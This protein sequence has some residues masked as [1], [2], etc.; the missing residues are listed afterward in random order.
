VG[1]SRLCC[2][3][4]SSG[5][6]ERRREYIIEWA[7]ANGW[8]IEKD[9]DGTVAVAV[10][11]GERVVSASFFDEDRIAMVQCLHSYIGPLLFIPCTSRTPELLAALATFRELSR[12][13]L[14]GFLTTLIDDFPG[15]TE[16]TGEEPHPI[17]ARLRHGLDIAWRHEELQPRAKAKSDDVGSPGGVAFSRQGGAGPPRRARVVARRSRR[18]GRGS[19]ARVGRRVC[20]RAGLQCGSRRSAG[21][22]G[23]PGQCRTERAWAR[24]CSYASGK[25]AASAS[26]SATARSA[27]ALASSCAPPAAAWT[28]ARFN[29]APACPPR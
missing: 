29:S 6:F 28:S 19:R 20:C 22:E 14:A 27:A 21:L 17:D 5:G 13:E 11:R 12:A 3:V 9:D 23:S 15:T 16:N 10:E 24:R 8:S 1:R 4:A 18:L 7:T 25:S 26:Y 2:G